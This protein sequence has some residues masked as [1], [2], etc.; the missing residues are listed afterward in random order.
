MEQSSSRKKITPP[1]FENGEPNIEI[2]AQFNKLSEELYFRLDNELAGQGFY[3][4]RPRFPT[5]N[6]VTINL[7]KDNPKDLVLSAICALVT[8]VCRYT[9]GK[10]PTVRVG[11]LM[12]YDW[13]LPP[14]PRIVEGAAALAV[15]QERRIATSI[16]NLN[17][18]SEETRSAVVSN[19]AELFSLLEELR[20]ERIELSY[21]G[22]GGSGSVNTYEV[23][24][25]HKD[26]DFFFT[27]PISLY[28]IKSGSPTV[29]VDLTVELWKCT[30]AEGLNSFCESLLALY[31]P[32][33]KNREGSIG[34][35]T[36]NVAD[37]TIELEHTSYYMES[38]EDS[39]TV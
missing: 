10:I 36:Y 21:E 7:K 8:T 6:V 12:H 17:N 13:R 32:D 20:V 18:L 34:T 24:G 38:E 11:H 1:T 37:K 29:G 27:K 2:T 33:W 30:I 9:D 26:Y 22:D 23:D 4:E 14:E 3:V 39:I 28:V 25:A 15:F 5:F 35:C 19:K 16:S 31:F